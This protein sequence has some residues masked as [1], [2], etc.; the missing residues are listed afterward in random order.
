MFSIER[1]A[2]LIPFCKIIIIILEIYHAIVSSEMFSIAR[3]VVQA[4]LIP[5]CKIVLAGGGGQCAP[6]INGFGCNG[7]NV[8]A[9]DLIDMMRTC[10]ITCVCVHNNI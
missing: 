3:K 7:S 6:D 4:V 2:A 5:F 9:H 10:F 1:K 8:C